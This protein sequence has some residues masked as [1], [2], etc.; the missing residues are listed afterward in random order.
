MNS[1]KKVYY[2]Y[3]E[4]GKA[5]LTDEKPDFNKIK[6]YTMVRADRIECVI[7]GKKNQGDLMLPDEPIDVASMLIN[8]TIT[9]E[10]SKFGT[11][12]PL[13]DKEPQT[14]A[15][16]DTNQLQEI[17][18]HLLAYCNAQEYKF[19]SF[20]R[21]PHISRIGSLNNT[22]ALRATLKSIRSVSPD[23]IRTNV[24][25]EI[26]NIEHKSACVSPSALLIAATVSPNFFE[27]FNLDSSS[28]LA[29]LMIVLIS[30][31]VFIQSLLLHILLL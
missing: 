21:N 28:I 25:L 14:F 17:T 2:V 4:N 9:V 10:P 6:N 18:E 29:S 20:V 12:S 15:K 13:H 23:S 11:L 26:P 30:S 3:T 22:D 8:A 19:K 31:L 5:I 7:G 27:A 1:N 16:Y 24:C